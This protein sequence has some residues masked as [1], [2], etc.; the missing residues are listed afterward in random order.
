MGFILT[1]KSDHFVFHGSPPEQIIVRDTATPE[2]KTRTYSVIADY[3][4]AERILCSGAYRADA[5]SIATLIG[6]HVDIPVTLTPI[7]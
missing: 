1:R 3:G 6:E 2:S 5:N 4:W 7:N